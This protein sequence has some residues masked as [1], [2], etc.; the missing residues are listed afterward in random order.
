MG[1]VDISG[2]QEIVGDMLVGGLLDDDDDVSGY[3]ELVGYDDD[4]DS[5]GWNPFRSKRRAP[6]R[7]AP[8]R[9]M[10][11]R[12]AAGVQRAAMANALAAKQVRGGSIV[13]E[14]NYSKSRQWILGFDSVTTVAAAATANITSNPQMPFRPRRLSVL[15]SVAGSFLLNNLVIGN[16]PQFAS[17]Q[18]AVPAD[19]FGPTSFGT[20]L[21]TDTAQP[22]T[23]VQLQV[24]NITGAALRFVAGIIGDAVS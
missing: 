7:G 4:D 19:M 22:N 13:K 2:V 1:M 11:P 14:H 6:K 8:T 21:Q 24:T 18:F 23:N 9:A 12:G 16:Q 5:V 10:V 17:L 15:G 3:E 20:D